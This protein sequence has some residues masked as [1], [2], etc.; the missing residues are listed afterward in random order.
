MS[1][2]HQ[3]LFELRETQQ[4]RGYRP[5]WVWY[6]LQQR[7]RWF[8]LE[9]LQLIAD[10]LD[11]RSGWVY[12]QFKEWG[13]PQSSPPPPPVPTKLRQALELLGLKLPIT[14]PTLKRAYR[15]LSIETHPD[16]GGSHEAFLHINQAY[17]YLKET[18]AVGGAVQC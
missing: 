10:V 6:Q 11:Y 3:E 16:T 8:S 2:L 15:R 9:D 12:H 1:F 13:P 5:G 4:Y 14:E 18:L 7:Y 17:E